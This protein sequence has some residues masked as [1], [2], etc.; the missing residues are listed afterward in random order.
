MTVGGADA[1]PNSTSGSSTL[2]AEAGIRLLIPIP[3]WPVLVSFSLSTQGILIRSNV[4]STIKPTKK[5][6][7]LNSKKLTNLAFA[8]SLVGV[9]MLLSFKNNLN[10]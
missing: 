4:I 1:F 3:D 2:E 8:S 9:L 7:V 10:S 5:S 6:Y